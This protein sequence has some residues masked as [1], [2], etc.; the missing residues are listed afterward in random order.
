MIQPSSLSF[1]NTLFGNTIKA[2]KRQGLTYVWYK[3]ILTE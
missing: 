3:N 2:M 1:Q